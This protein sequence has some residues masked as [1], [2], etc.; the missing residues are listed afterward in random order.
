M[1]TPADRGRFLEILGLVAERYEWRVLA[2]C[3]MTNHYHLLVQTPKA[4][5]AR[6]MRQLNGVYA[7]SFNRRYRRD[8]HLFQGRYQARL[9]Q[10]DEEA[11]SRYCAIVEA[12]EDPPGPA[13]PLLDGDDRFVALQLE[14][15]EPSPE[16][17]RASLRVPRPPL[18]ELLTTSAD[19]TSIVRAPR[20]RVQHAPDRDPPRLRSHDHP[21]ADSRV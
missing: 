13:H 14:R 6:G 2:Y 10:A 16:H 11:R 18:D 3:L 5:L 7:Q 8:G 4:N 1:A 21:P 20:A 17:P 15:L 9:V 19:A 12:D